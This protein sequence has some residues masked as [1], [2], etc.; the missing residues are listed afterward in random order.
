MRNSNM[1]LFITGVTVDLMAT[2]KEYE[3]MYKTQTGKK[4]RDGLS[5]NDMTLRKKNSI[6]FCQP[7]CEKKNRKKKLMKCP[8]TYTYKQVTEVITKL[9]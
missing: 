8:A 4:Y 7:S 5:N 1:W 9:N 3:L 6:W 2:L